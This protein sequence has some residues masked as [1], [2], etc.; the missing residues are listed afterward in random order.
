MY[1]LMLPF[2][3]QKIFTFYVNG[4]LNCNVQLQGRRVNSHVP[5]ITVPPSLQDTKQLTTS[6]AMCVC[7]NVKLRRVRV[8]IVA[9]DKQ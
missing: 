5:R 9:V 7:I 8:T 4:V 6:Q 2:L 3:V 1:F